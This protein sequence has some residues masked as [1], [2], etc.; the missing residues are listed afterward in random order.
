L[1]DGVNLVGVAKPC[2]KKLC[3]ISQETVHLVLRE[4]NYTVY[5]HREECF[6][7]PI[8]V[9]SNVGLYRALHTTAVGK[10]IMAT[11]S[12]DEIADYWR[13]IDKTKVTPNTIDELSV[14]LRDIAEA[15]LRGFAIDNEENTLGVRCIA[16]ALVD[17]TGS[18]NAAISISGYKDRMDDKRMQELKPAIFSARDTIMTGMGYVK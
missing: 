17:Y 5:L 8:R 2:L 1:I 18:H 10:S 4:G 12:D 15:R 3:D 14:L 16:V 7:S 11:M 9:I 13:R 6:N